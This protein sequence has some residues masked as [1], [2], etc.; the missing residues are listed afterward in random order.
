M[1]DSF[2]IIGSVISG[3]IGFY[4]GWI[5]RGII[6]GRDNKDNATILLIGVSLVWVISVLFDIA[7]TNYETPLAVHALMGA[8]VGYFYKERTNGHT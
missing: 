6:D 5:A 1:F 7:S 3:A 4:V 8:L 2:N